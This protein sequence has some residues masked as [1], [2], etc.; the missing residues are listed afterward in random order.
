MQVNIV[1]MLLCKKL[2]DLYEQ[3][4]KPFLH[5]CPKSETITHQMG[6]EG[7]KAMLKNNKDLGLLGCNAMSLGN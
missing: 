5:T 4:L 3:V 7:K 1:Y 6:E 2:R